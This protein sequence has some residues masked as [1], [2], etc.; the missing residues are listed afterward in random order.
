MNVHKYR[1]CMDAVDAL[2]AK[3]VT[4]IATCLDENAVSIDDVDFS[5]YGKVCM[6]FGNEE[7][8]LSWALRNAAD[9]KVYIPM[10]GFSQSFNISVSCAIALYHLRQ[11]GLVVPD[12]DDDQMNHLYLHWLLMS[13]KKAASVVKK[14][15]HETEVPHFM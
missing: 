7:R 4:L 12:L 5:Q 3:G 15:G 10:S 11:K 8:G 2:R 14:H 13:T 6:M 1:H 9:L